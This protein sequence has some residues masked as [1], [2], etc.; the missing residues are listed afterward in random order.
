MELSKRLRILALTPPPP[1]INLYVHFT[2]AVLLFLIAEQ[3]AVEHF[4][5]SIDTIIL[6][7]LCIIGRSRKRACGAVC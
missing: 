7:V 6:I 2:I 5:R 4:Y 3:T 1:G